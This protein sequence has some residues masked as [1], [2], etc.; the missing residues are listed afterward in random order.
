[1]ALFAGDRPPLVWVDCHKYK[2]RVARVDWLGVHGFALSVR[3]AKVA[4]GQLPDGSRR[5]RAW[6]YP[7]GE[8]RD[9][10]LAN[11]ALPES[12]RA[13]HA[14]GVLCCCRCG[15]SAVAPTQLPRLY[16]IAVSCQRSGNVGRLTAW[17]SSA[18]TL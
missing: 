11:L 13:V 7:L 3:A 2:C 14:G 17:H 4:P 18:A 9:E 10:V 15:F 12:E 6:T 16:D 1:M 8:L 5:M